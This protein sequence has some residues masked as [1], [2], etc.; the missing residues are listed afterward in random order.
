VVGRA[1]TSVAA[2]GGLGVMN[3]NFMSAEMDAANGRI[4]DLINQENDMLLKTTIAYK[5]GD[6]KA[7]NAAQTAYDKANTDK[8]KAISDLATAAN[9]AVKLS[10]AQAKIDAQALKDGIANDNKVSLGIAGS[11]VD[12]ITNS[13]LKGKDLETY[14]QELATAN[15]ISNPAILQTAI[16]TEQAKRT[17]G[18]LANKNVQSTINNR[19]KSSTVKADPNAAKFN[20]VETNTMYG[21]GVNSSDLKVIK[22]NITKYGAQAVIDNASI[23]DNIKTILESKYGMTRTTK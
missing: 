1:N 20:T 7:L 6:I 16:D 22:D 4:S 18:N 15:G 9:N 10:Q 17:K 11:A 2:S 19:G 23:P 21:A 5:D 14:V 3:D 13:G 12:Q 8:L